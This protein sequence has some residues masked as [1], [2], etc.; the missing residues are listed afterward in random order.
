MS[1]FKTL[2][3]IVGLVNTAL[4]WIRKKRTPKKRDNV[5]TRK[6]EQTIEIFV[7]G[8]RSIVVPRL[9]VLLTAIAV[10]AAVAW[11][12]SRLGAFA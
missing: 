2:V 9:L 12:A 1:D 6:Q 11:L 4:S 3:T 10:V 5:L 8:Q 7:K